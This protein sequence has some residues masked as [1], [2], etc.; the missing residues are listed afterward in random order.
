MSPAYKPSSSLALWLLVITASLISVFMTQFFLIGHDVADSMDSSANLLRGLSIN[1]PL[2]PHDYPLVT[3]VYAIPVLIHFVLPFLDVTSAFIFFVLLLLHGSALLTWAILRRIPE[4]SDPNATFMALLYF[5]YATTALALIQVNVHFGEREN[6]AVIAMTPYLWSCIAVIYNAPLPS[7]LRIASG[8]LGAAGFCLKPYFV[9]I[10]AASELFLVIRTRKVLAWARLETL[11]IGAL[12]AFYLL[13][14]W[15]WYPAYFAELG[16]AMTALGQYNNQHLLLLIDNCL[17]LG[18]VIF[19]LFIYG[20]LTRRNE[21]RWL[22]TYGFFL[23]M[24]SLATM[25]VQGRGF[26]NHIYFVLCFLFFMALILYRKSLWKTLTAGSLLT[27]LLLATYEDRL[28][29]GTSLL[30]EKMSFRR[31]HLRLA[32]ELSPHIKEQK[33]TTLN[34]Q[35]IGLWPALTLS[36]AEWE[37]AERN[38]HYLYS[39]YAR[40]KKCCVGPES[41]MPD[42]RYLQDKIIR[43]LEL[44]KTEWV[45]VYNFS[46]D[47]PIDIMHHFMMD[48]R[49]RNLWSNYR[50]VTRS[51]ASF[52]R[53][54]KGTFDLYRRLP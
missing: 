11:I 51:E 38:F 19:G 5:Y 45:L 1:N 31:E 28:W 13:A 21:E 30:E 6:L 22:L 7:R 24:A 29:P 37:G 54:D 17:T 36:G 52:T 10:F 39:V 25:Y 4:F 47:L 9:L 44:N 53:G 14:W 3:Y 8:I 46:R 34:H 49:F 15:L 48:A 41:L 12:G 50:L 42:E 40:H 2:K 20:F 27:F 32:N 35:I 33:V 43:F 18:A 23:A 16:H 26:S